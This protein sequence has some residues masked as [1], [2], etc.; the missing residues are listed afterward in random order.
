MWEFIGERYIYRKVNKKHCSVWYDVYIHRWRWSVVEF[1]DLG[2]K[3]Q[4]GDAFT[5]SMAMK[6]TA[7]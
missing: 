3:I 7:D 2:V 1:A 6:L 4:Q 5:A